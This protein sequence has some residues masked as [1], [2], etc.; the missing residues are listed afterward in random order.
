MTII[1][2]T[3][4]NRNLNSHTLVVTT[5][6]IR[7]IRIDQTVI[8]QLRL[9]MIQFAYQI[10]RKLKPYGLSLN[11]EYNS[12]KIILKHHFKLWTFRL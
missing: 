12:S 2:M 5:V 3:Y 4:K 9:K 6:I 11:F 10:V 7:N 8:I 1:Q